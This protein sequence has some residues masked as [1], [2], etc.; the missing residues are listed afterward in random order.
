MSENNN[1]RYKLRVANHG[2][3]L[4]TSNTLDEITTKIKSGIKD[5]STD[6]SKYELYE[7]GKIKYNG[8]C[9]QIIEKITRSSD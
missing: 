7:N 5:F 4:I 1:F 8:T 9:S 3:V 6:I 2:L